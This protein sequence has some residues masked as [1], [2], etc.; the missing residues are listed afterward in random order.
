VPLESR[1]LWGI[2]ACETGAVPG[3]SA[4]GSPSREQPPGPPRTCE[5]SCQRTLTSQ[6]GDTVRTGTWSIPTT[7]GLIPAA[8]PRDAPGAGPPRSGWHFRPSV[9][10]GWHGGSRRR[11][12]GWRNRLYRSHS[13]AARS[14]RRVKG[15]WDTTNPP[16]RAGNGADRKG[17]ASGGEDRS[18]TQTTVVT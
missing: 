3:D 18:R 17:G 2:C 10:T 11:W 1:Q 7:A 13:G 14:R 12:R 4:G 6:L 8:L 16:R 9:G 15:A 5:R